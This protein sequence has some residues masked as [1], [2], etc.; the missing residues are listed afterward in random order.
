MKEEQVYQVSGV[1]W[2][3]AA[4]QCE[5]LEKAARPDMFLSVDAEKQARMVSQILEMA[6]GMPAHELLSLAI[7]FYVYVLHLVCSGSSSPEGEGNGRSSK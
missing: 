4:Q 6:S 2:A 1:L 7:A 3:L 5:G